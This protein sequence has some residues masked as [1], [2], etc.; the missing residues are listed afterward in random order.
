VFKKLLIVDFAHKKK[1]AKVLVGDTAQKIAIKSLTL[2]CKGRGGDL[3][4][5]VAI[6]DKRF[7][8]VSIVRP[9]NEFLSKEVTIMD[10]V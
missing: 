9:M 4:N 8:D 3:F 2:L 7:G 6:E 5:D 1:I 10:L